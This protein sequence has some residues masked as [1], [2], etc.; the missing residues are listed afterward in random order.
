MAAFG[1]CPL[2]YI[3]LSLTP[4]TV[5]LKDNIQRYQS[6]VSRLHNKEEYHYLVEDSTY[7]FTEFFPNNPFTRQ[8][9]K[10]FF[11]GNF[12]KLNLCVMDNGISE[13][14][15]RTTRSYRTWRD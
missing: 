10:S 3:R 14:A 2:C 13:C 15:G 6:F 9:H 5:L 4:A 8:A 7:D 11:T 1:S 12:P